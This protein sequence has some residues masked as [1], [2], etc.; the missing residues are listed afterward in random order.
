MYAKTWK[1]AGPHR[2]QQKFVGARVTLNISPN[3]SE[4]ICI[5]SRTPE[6]PGFFNFPNF[7]QWIY[8][9]IQGTYPW[10]MYFLN[11]ISLSSLKLIDC[12]FHT[13]FPVRLFTYTAHNNVFACAGIKDTWDGRG[14]GGS[15][16]VWFLLWGIEPSCFILRRAKYTWIFA[17]SKFYLLG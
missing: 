12:Y 9:N 10:I 3:P 8:W 4:G 15:Q 7:L 1:S 16:N 17:I 5:V 6:Q 2:C 14:M 11:G 13:W